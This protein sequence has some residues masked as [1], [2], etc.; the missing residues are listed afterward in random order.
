[1]KGHNLGWKSGLLIIIASMVWDVMLIKSVGVL[2]NHIPDL[3][4]WSWDIAIWAVKLINFY[5]V[6]VLG[7]TPYIIY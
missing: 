7:A 5:C 3:P 4:I 1:M 6:K 2:Y